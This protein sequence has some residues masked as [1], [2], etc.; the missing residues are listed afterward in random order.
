[1][2]SM[3]FQFQVAPSY[4]M[5]YRMRSGDYGICFPMIYEYLLFQENMLIPVQWLIHFD[6]HGYTVIKVDFLAIL[7]CVV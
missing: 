4:R 5:S 1:M 2:S 6:Y 3:N 7:L